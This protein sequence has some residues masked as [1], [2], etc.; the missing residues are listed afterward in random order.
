MERREQQVK[1]THAHAVPNRWMVRLPG[2]L[3]HPGILV[4]DPSASR[5]LA[6][7]PTIAISS[8]SSHLDRNVGDHGRDHVALARPLALRK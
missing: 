6:F 7:A 5:I 3:D 4:A 2:L 1:S 8:S